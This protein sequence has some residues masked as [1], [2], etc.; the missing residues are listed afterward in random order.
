MTSLP[1]QEKGRD[2]EGS[3]IILTSSIV[4]GFDKLIQAIKYRQRQARYGVSL[5][6][7]LYIHIGF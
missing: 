1:Y 5:F 4:A 3:S 6:I 7:P 2:L